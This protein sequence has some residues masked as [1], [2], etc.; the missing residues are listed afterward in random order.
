MLICVPKKYFEWR[1]SL[2]G[3]TKHETELVGPLNKSSVHF[4]RAR[5]AHKGTWS[6]LANPKMRES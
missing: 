4:S 3:A 1:P 6:N 5:G 2:L